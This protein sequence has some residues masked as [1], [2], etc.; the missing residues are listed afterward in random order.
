MTDPEAQWIKAARQGDAQAFRRLVEQHARPLHRVCQRVLGD[1]AAAEDALQDALLNAWRGL[2]RFDGRSA[3]GSWLHRIA[4]N[5][6]LVQLRQRRPEVSLDVA[7]DDDDAH[8]PLLPDS[9]E[10]PFEHAS[11][12]QFGRRLAVALDALSAAERSAFVLRHF[13]H[14]PLEEIAAV[15]GCNVNACKQSVFRAV[16]KL[17]L[18][19]TPS[20]SSS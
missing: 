7:D 3:F 6:A 15:L 13:E 18:A 11:G 10:D 1:A 12:Q 9:H 4:V 8:A 17:R 20:R 2:E 19:L 16:R 5:A 14:Y